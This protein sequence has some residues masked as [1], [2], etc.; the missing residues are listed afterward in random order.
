MANFQT[1]TRK[2][3]PYQIQIGSFLFSSLNEQVKFK[4]NDCGGSLTSVIVISHAGC[5]MSVKISEYGVSADFETPEYW[6]IYTVLKHT[7]TTGV[8]D[9][10]FVIEE[11][12]I[13]SSRVVCK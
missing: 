3:A 2:Y 11:Y 12:E 6:N 13:T 9:R 10:E 4:T 5:V 7:I 8:A 1:S